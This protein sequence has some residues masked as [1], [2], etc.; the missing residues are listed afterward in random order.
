MSE[1]VPVWQSNVYTLI[2]HSTEP[3]ILMMPGQGGWSLPSFQFGLQLRFGDVVSVMGEVWHTLSADITA[4]RWTDIRYTREDT[5]NRVDIILTLECNNP[6]W[7]P[8]AQMQWIGREALE[9]LPLA[10]V[11][12]REVIMTCLREEETQIVPALRPPWERRGWFTRAVSWIHAQLEQLGYTVMAPIEQVRI[13]GISCILQVPTTMGIVYF[14]AGPVSVAGGRETFPFFFANEAALIKELVVLYPEHI[15][16]PLALEA[17]QGWMLLEDFGQALRVQPVLALWEEALLAFSRIQLSS[18][19]HV[20]DLLR[21]GCLDRRLDKMA[22]HI[23]TLMSDTEALS[24]LDKAEADQLQAYAP[25]FKAMCRQLAGYT[26]PVT[27]V[28]GDLHPGNVALQKGKPVFFDWADGCVSHPF[29]DATTFWGAAYILE[30]AAGS[31]RQLHDA[32]L[33][34]WLA[35]EPIER[36]IEAAELAKVLGTMYQVLR[37]RDIMANMEPPWDAVMGQFVA[38]WVRKLLEAVAEYNRQ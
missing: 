14:K 20:E 9:S 12:Q 28:H 16:S 5:R 26:L 2:F 17:E 7:V 23:D 22:K 24:Y 18:L 31:R 37:N 13:W 35:Y 4:V 30:D 6:A 15:P 8:P 27:L 33:A 34:Q 38:L 11:Q 25:L 21:I 29:F 32:Y 36:L 19:G 10:L 1:I 3:R